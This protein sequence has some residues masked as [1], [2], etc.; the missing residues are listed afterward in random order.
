[1]MNLLA[2][3]HLLLPVL[4]GRSAAMQNMAFI[5]IHTLSLCARMASS[6]FQWNV[7]I[8]LAVLMSRALTVE[9][10]LPVS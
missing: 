1:M 9:I 7:E 8:P 6:R 3:V 10:I 4:T 2:N 5:A